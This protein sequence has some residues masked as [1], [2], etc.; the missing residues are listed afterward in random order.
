MADGGT[1]LGE[2]RI[3]DRAVACIGLGAM[4]MS[5]AGRPDEE[6]STATIHVALDRGVTLID[7]ADAYCTGADEFGHNEE[8]VA[9]AVRAWSGDR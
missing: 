8:L 1:P 3:G 2:R 5:V 4:P 9:R 7:T 6:R